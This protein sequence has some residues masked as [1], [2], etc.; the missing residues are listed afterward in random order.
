MNG[1][2]KRITLLGT[3][4]IFFLGGY[5]S[6]ERPA[7]DL[8]PTG[9]IPL[10]EGQVKEIVEGWPRITGVNVNW[11]GFERINEVKAQRGKVPLDPR[12]IRP[13]GREVE[14]TIG[15]RDVSLQAAAMS[16]DFAADLPAFV[17]NSELK[18]FPP[19]RSQ[20]PLGSCVSFST[21]Y[22]Q[23]SYMTA[24]KRDLDIRDNN[25]NTNKYSPKWSYTM[26][27]G[28]SDEGSSFTAVYR[29]LER[30]GAA[31][32]AEFPYDGDYLAWCM[33]SSAWRNALSVRTNPTQYVYDVSTD[34]G[35]ESIKALLTNGYVL[36]FGTYISSW[37]YKTIQDDPTTTD[38]DP[39][40]G[41]EVGYW[42]DG[43]E[44]SHAMTIVGY[45][46]EIWTDI[47]DDGLVDWGEKGAFRIANSWG[48]WWKDGGFVWLAYDALRSVSAVPFG[49]SGGRTQAFQ[50]DMTFVL[51][52][53][54]LD[55][56]L[57]IAEF[58]VNHEKRNQL[59]M[60]LGRSDTSATTPSTSWMPRA[61]SYQGGAYAFDGSTTAVDG[62]FVYD[63]S[64]LL[65]EGGAPLR[66]YLGMRD[67]TAGD[68]ATLSAFKI[69]DLTTDPPTE[70][71]SSLVPQTADDQQV[72]AYLDY[73]YQG[74]AYNHPPSLSYPRVDPAS[75]KTTETYSFTIHYRDDDGDVPSVAEVRIDDNP[76]TMTYDWGISPSDGYYRFETALPAGS[77]EF[78]FHF[79]D[80]Q[81]GSAR[82]PIAG[83][84]GGP[85]VFD[86]FLISLSPS[87]AMAGDPAF[88][89]SVTGTD[90][91]DGAVVMWDGSD[92]PT[93][94]V[95]SSLVEAEIGTD[96][97]ADGGT[98]QV[99]V[100]LP[101]GAVSNAMEFT[102]NNPQ[103]SLTSLDPAKADGGGG[104]FTLT[105]LGSHFVPGS[106]V[107]WSGTGKTTTYVSSTELQISVS[108]ADIAAGGE[109]ELTVTNPPP[110]G[111]ASNGIIFPV[112]SFTT[113]V[114][115]TNLTV[116]AG[117][118]ATFTIQLVPQVSSFDSPVSFYCLGLPRGC[119]ASFSPAS[120]TPGAGDATVTM[121]ISTTS[122]QNSGIGTTAGSAGPV[123]PALALGLVLA[124]VSFLLLM[125]RRAFQGPAR[126]WLVSLAVLCLVV[127]L[128]V[129]SP[130]GSGNSSNSGTPAGTYGI[131]VRSVS[132][133]L[134]V[135]D[136]VTLVVQ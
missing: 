74:P 93:T 59:R 30:H 55:T 18:F 76:Q 98:F 81:G 50:S 127:L 102:V 43:T 97:L 80:G 6:Q 11:L 69:I 5:A 115:P 118:S 71:E 42:L 31:T 66:Y 95:D 44:G 67:S 68:V 134:T 36:V 109:V 62:T 65:G 96:D 101:G 45:N 58:T 22:T 15:R 48:N 83:A 112:A 128:A 114:T 23:L 34:P 49:P 120:V 132:G 63:F 88:T 78:Y 12:S 13:V 126:R 17:D 79:E 104:G 60:S 85:E 136:S 106:F 41:E 28:G 107:R 86:L 135:L 29:L 89:L 90:F 105:L 32:W 70:V 133:G 7:A 14:S 108:A 57:M 84:I 131:Q 125:Y 92:R 113:D 72:Y 121:T 52:V 19:I 54:D 73:L 8:Y 103:P 100:R 26:V 1:T 122:R 39:E 64:E 16:P 37:N 47:N 56:P 3:L 130:T 46:D 110:A 27:N 38:D 61:I 87:S 21:T 91:I 20:N 2:L 123:P 77:H 10:D 94:F 99:S 24:L 75:G 33:S 53:R 4:G 51:T 124:A 119:S 25:D 35:L 116:T 111:G 129:C 82:A 9:L 40:V 117:Q